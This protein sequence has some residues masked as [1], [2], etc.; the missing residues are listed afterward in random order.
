MTCSDAL[1]TVTEFLDG[2]LSCRQQLIPV[3]RRGEDCRLPLRDVD[4]RHPGRKAGFE[5]ASSQPSVGDPLFYRGGD[6]ETELLIASGACCF[7]SKLGQRA[8]NPI[9]TVVTGRDTLRAPGVKLP[10]AGVQDID[11]AQAWAPH[12]SA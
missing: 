11:P 5:N 2:L 9:Q 12:V 1:Q 7:A 6:S 10:W 8:G 3:P 4:L